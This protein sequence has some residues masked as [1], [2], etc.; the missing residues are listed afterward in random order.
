[1]ITASTALPAGTNRMIARGDFNKPDEGFRIR[2]RFDLLAGAF[3]LEGGDFG[4][5]GVE[6]R[7]A[8]SVV[9]HVQKQIAA[10]DAQ[11]DHADI[12]CRGCHIKLL[13]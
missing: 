3:G 9:G 8:E 6:T 10:H 5:I 11:A 12:V 2:R 1:M 4:G 13:W 7:H